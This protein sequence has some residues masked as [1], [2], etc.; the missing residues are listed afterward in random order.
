MTAKLKVVPKDE[1]L[2]VDLYGPWRAE[3]AKRDWKGCHVRGDRSPAVELADA[4]RWQGF[5]K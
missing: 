5:R 4:P 2:I 3:I 1:P